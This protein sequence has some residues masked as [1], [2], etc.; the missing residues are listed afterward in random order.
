ML[1]YRRYRIAALYQSP[2][3]NCTQTTHGDGKQKDL[4]RN[5]QV[6]VQRVK[7]KQTGI[8][9]INFPSAPKDF[10]YN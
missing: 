1:S 5:N 4:Q 7:D 6:K 3:H 9:E 8:G 2:S 10:H